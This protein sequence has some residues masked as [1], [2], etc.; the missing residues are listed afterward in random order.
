M[1]SSYPFIQPVNVFL[2]AGDELVLIDSGEGTNH[3]M[4]RLSSR[5][6]D[7]GFDL[8]DLSMIINTHDHI[9]HF[10]GN[11]AL[12]DISCAKIL[13]HRLA[14]PFIEDMGNHAPQE[15][16]L[17]DLPKEV[18]NFIKV[19]SSMYRNLTT[20]KVDIGL[21]GNE[22]IPVGDFVL[23]II[24]TPGHTRGH[25]CIYEEGEE[26]LFAGD[27]IMKEGTPYIGA[28]PPQYG[29]MVD[30]LNSIRRLKDLNL[31][32]LLPSHGEEVRD[33][34]KRIEETIQ[35]KLRRERE[36][37]QVLE[38]GGKTLQEIVDL[39]YG[40]SVL[41]Y[42]AYGAALAYL[43]KLNGEGKVK[44]HRGLYELVESLT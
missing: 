41:P 34:Y 7:L 17:K 22:L 25:I 21:E 37:Q 9:E 4:E 42:F 27:L 11:A 6:E 32:R 36:V 23:R 8:D 44:K 33:P 24:H 1:K 31:R 10:G 13:A 29:D 15:S 18:T 40:E 43:E 26:T 19:R 5:F 16:E 14:I 12:K 2:L 28:L 35:S 39:I 38:R 3:S 30:F 20:A